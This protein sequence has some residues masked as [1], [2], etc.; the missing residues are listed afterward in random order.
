MQL[1]L[2][3]RLE[4]VHARVKAKIIIIFGEVKQGLCRWG[5]WGRDVNRSVYVGLGKFVDA[6]TGNISQLNRTNSL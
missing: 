5:G 6:A 1:R 3:R 4:W 2:Y